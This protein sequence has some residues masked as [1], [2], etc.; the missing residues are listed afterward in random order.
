MAN[1]AIRDR[2]AAG[3]AAVDCWISGSS[4]LS[5]EVMGRLGFDSV[6]IDMQHT[7]AEYRDVVTAVIALSASSTVPVVRV[8]GLDPILVGRVLD[9]GAR[10]VMCPMIS[11]PEQAE[12]FVAACRYPPRGTRS[13]GPYRAADG[14]R[15]FDEANADIVT[16]AQIETLEAMS[17]LDAIAATPG[18]DVLFVGPTDLSISGGGKPVMAYT[19]PLVDEQHRAIVDAAHRAGKRAGMLALAPGDAQIGRG[20]GMDFLSVAMEQRLVAV[21][22]AQ[23]LKEGRAAARTALERT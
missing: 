8:P 4:V 9:A 6:V 5:A 15:Y 18:L 20:W 3:E 21:G 12:R 22:A 13:Y 17:N 16:F 19:D 1:N 7:M 23:A 2:W 10:G 14:V 11:T